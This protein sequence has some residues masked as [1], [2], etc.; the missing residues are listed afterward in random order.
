MLDSKKH[1]RENIPFKGGMDD[2][3]ALRPRPPQRPV[4]KE[5]KKGK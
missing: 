4:P 5:P 1:S 3:A 2:L